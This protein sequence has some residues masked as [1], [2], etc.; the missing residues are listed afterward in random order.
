MNKVFD[1]YSS[2]CFALV[3]AL[4]VIESRNISTSAYGS[5]VGPNMFPMGLGIILIILSLRLFWEST[6]SKAEGSAA[7]GGKSL[8]YKR[9]LTIFAATLLYVYLLEPVGYVIMTFLFLF[10]T[11]K[12]MGSKSYFKTT[13]VSFAFSVGV[14]YVYVHLLQ[15]TLPGFPVW[16]GF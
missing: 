13:L 11:F 15:G 4:F 12:V 1:R 7:T 14:Y 9:F 6:R 5:E 16:L 2:V 3:G 10:V 8:Q